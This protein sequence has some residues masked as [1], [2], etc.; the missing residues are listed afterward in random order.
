MKIGEIL[1]ELEAFAPL[2]LQEEYD[3][4]GLLTGQR[5]D[6][7]SGAL[8]CLDCTEEVVDEAIALGINLVIAHHPIIFKGLKKINGSNYIERTII[9]AIKYNIAIY[10]C[11]TNLDNVKAGVNQKI[12]EKLGLTNLHILAPKSG[13]LKKLITY[14]PVKQ[15]QQVLDALFAAGAGH[16]GNYSHCS[17]NTSGTG[18]FQGQEGTNPFIGKP[19]ELSTEPEIKIETIFESYNETNIISALMQSHP[20]EEVAF[21]VFQLTNKHNAIGSGMIGQL[22]E[23]MEEETFLK[24]VKSVFMVPSIRHTKKTGK[25]IKKVAVCGGSGS[26]LLKNALS[27]GV[28]AYVTADV[29]YHEFFDAENKL[30]LIDTGHFES[31]QFTPEIF[32]DIIK[33]KFNTFAVH[34]SKINTNPINYF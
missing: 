29:K 26:F 23:P 32:Y 28:D 15:H 16:I 8:L 25:T 3:N 11:H 5:N 1:K 12:G 19:N 24:L 30:L 31:E 14:V 34:L 33:K 9:K 18:T 10:A 4:C 7:V 22:V 17:F 21:D 20:Y 27:A 6:E 13:L 2:S